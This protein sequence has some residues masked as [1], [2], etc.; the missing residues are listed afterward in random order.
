MQPLF[1]EV[2]SLESGSRVCGATC[3]V[4]YCASTNCAG[5]IYPF[6]Q[7][8]PHT[9]GIAPH[10]WWLTITGVSVAG[11]LFVALGCI[12]VYIIFI[13]TIHGSRVVLLL[14]RTRSAMTAGVDVGNSD[15]YHGWSEVRAILLATWSLIIIHGICLTMVGLSLPRH[16]PVTLVLAPLLFQWILVSP[17]Y[18]FLP[19]WITR[20]HVTRWKRAER[21][22]LHELMRSETGDA[23]RRTLEQRLTDLRRI[24]VNPFSGAIQ[25]LLFTL[26]TIASITFVVE[27]INHLYN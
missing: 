19:Y 9:Y 4:A 2:G 8:A 7:V 27:I 21:L 1:R 22:L 5:R 17:V 23:V 15:G 12:V 14:W 13:Q 20:R 18:L 6:L 11:M 26:G 10:N 25:A 24:R 3:C 16:Q